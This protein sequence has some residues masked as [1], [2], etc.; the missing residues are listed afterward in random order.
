VPFKE[1]VFP[2]GC[3]PSLAAIVASAARVTDLAVIDVRD[4]GA[5]YPETL[6][7]W[8]SNLPRDHADFRLFRLYLCYCEAAFLERHVSDVQVVFAGRRWRP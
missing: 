1:A 8:R 5:H 7:R 4:I 2:G 6:C 3:L